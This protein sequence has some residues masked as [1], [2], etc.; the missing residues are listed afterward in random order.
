MQV[1]LI[2][3]D[4]LLDHFTVGMQHRLSQLVSFVLGCT[5][6]TH[7]GPNSRQPTVEIGEELM[8]LDTARIITVNG[9]EQLRQHLCRIALPHQQLLNLQRCMW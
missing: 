8:L 1:A 6:H 7:C 9:F 4:Q 3:L 2:D 5:E